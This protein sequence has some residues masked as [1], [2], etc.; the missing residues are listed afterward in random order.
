MKGWKKRGIKMKMDKVAGSGNDEFYTPYY[1]V[2]PIVKYIKENSKIWC[3]FD[4][5]NSFFVKTLVAEGHEVLATHI[6][7]GE[8]FFNLKD[9]EIV[10]WCDY[11]I[12]NPPYSL[13]TEVLES[14]FETKKP[15]AMLL[16]VVGLFESQRRFELFRDNDFEI[17]YMNRRVDYFKDFGEVKPS[18]SPPFS[19]VYITSKILPEKII[20]EEINKKELTN[21]NGVA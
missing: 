7:N 6:S 4:N 15:F 8:D 3:P 5:R 16:G 9:S 18:K 21:D 1:A 12:S 10:D 20:F 19:S 13:K 17:M 2:K 14:L 11:V